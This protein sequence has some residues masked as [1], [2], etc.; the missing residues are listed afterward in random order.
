MRNLT[1]VVTASL[2]ALALAQAAEARE[3]RWSTGNDLQGLDPHVHNHGVTNA[4][5]LNIYEPLVYLRPDGTIAAS[6]ATEWELVNPTTWRFRLRQNVRFHGGEPF[7]ADDV[8]FS[9]TRI[10]QPE[11]DMSY[12]V[13]SV[14]RIVKVDD[15]TID[16]VT[17][18][19]NPTLLRD[20]TLFFIMS[21]SW[22][23]RN[24]AMAMTRAAG[25]ST[26]PELNA[27]GTGAFRVIERQIDVRTVAEPNPNY[28]GQRNNNITRA[29]FRPIANTATRVAALLSGEL[30]LVYPIPFQ[31]IQRVS[32]AP[33]TRV[34]QGPSGRTIYLGLDVF[35]D[36]SLDM[37]GTGRNPLKDV[38]VR[39]AIYHA[40][41]EATIVRVV[42]R[43]STQP[44]G[45]FIAPAI[46]GY[47][48]D[49][50][51]RLPFNPDRARQLLTE[52]G[53]PNGFPLTLSCPNNRYVNDEAIC[54]AI[55]PMLTRVGIQAR[56]NAQPMIQ[57]VNNANPPGYNVS[58]FMLGWTPG[59]FDVSNP[60]GE[61]VGVNGAYNW[62]R[63]RNDRLE[64]L[65][66]QIVNETNPERRNTLVREALTILRTD[67]PIIP[68]HYEPQVMGILNTVEDFTLHAQED[69]R[70]YQVRMRQ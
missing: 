10:R 51:D 26:F 56:L 13:G 17:R 44:A 24:N 2:V 29:T 48:Q 43:G 42:M 22:V 62:G 15:F 37:P 45:L 55:I 35:R 38:R 47:Q 53:Y 31:D 39:Q 52:A 64:A 16:V 4:Y 32:S 14:E 8:L 54:T 11:S 61:L 6:L 58:L 36:E 18:G 66:P 34:V 3:F 9:F 68:L 19:P 28:W 7:T 33:N 41:D 70:L 12:T 50:S 59:N 46:A 63:Y 27:N 57:H 40:I 1:K 60:L 5:K 69:V 23:E 20:L 65:R 25:A 30:D 21:K 67:L 49:M